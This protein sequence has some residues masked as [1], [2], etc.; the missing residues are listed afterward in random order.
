MNAKNSVT[1]AIS[2]NPK[3]DAIK[4][5]KGI[6]ELISTM[7]TPGI[8]YDIRRDQSII[9]KDRLNIVISNILLAI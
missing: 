7:S 1:L 8:T 6:R 9:I 4:I 5:S 2:Q 3:G